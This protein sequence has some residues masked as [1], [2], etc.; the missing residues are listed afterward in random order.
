MNRNTEDPH[1]WMERNIGTNAGLNALWCVSAWFLCGEGDSGVYVL[2]LEESGPSGWGIVSRICDDEADID[3]TEDLFIGTFQQVQHIVESILR[4]KQE[5]LQ[6][7]ANGTVPA[8]VDCFGDLDDH[9]DCAM[10]G[11]RGDDGWFAA[12]GQS[13]VDAGVGSDARPEVAC[14]PEQC[15]GGIHDSV[16]GWG[17]HADAANALETTLSTWLHA[18]A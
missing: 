8:N 13:C 3:E 4:G 17:I 14:D 18:R 1:D 11:G 6:D 16:Y 5:I 15:K 9:T 2:D 10:Y 7:I 12:L